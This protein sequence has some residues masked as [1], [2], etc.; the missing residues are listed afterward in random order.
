MENK[1]SELQVASDL[2]HGS[3]SGGS[4]EKNAEDAKPATKKKGKHSLRGAIGK[5]E[6]VAVA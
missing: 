5:K 1:S 2:T 6:K 4:Q 3:R